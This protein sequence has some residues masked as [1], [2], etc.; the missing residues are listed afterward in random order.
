MGEV[1]RDQAAFERILGEIRT[2]TKSE[3][4][5]AVL[6]AIEDGYARYRDELERC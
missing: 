2:W 6:N 4:E 5:Q 3:E 1:A